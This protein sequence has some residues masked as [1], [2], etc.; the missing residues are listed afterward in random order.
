M[1]ECFGG[2]VG[3]SGYTCFLLFS[4]ANGFS[5]CPAT[6]G[7]SKPLRVALKMC[8]P[9][10]GQDWPSSWGTPPPRWSQGWGR[11][12][13]RLRSLWLALR[14]HCPTLRTQ[15]LRPRQTVHRL[16]LLAQS[17]GRKESYKP[18]CSVL[19]GA[20]ALD[21]NQGRH[22]VRVCLLLNLPR[23][24]SRVINQAAEPS[25][26]K[27]GIYY[28]LWGIPFSRFQTFWLLEERHPS[29]QEGPSLQ[30]VAGCSRD[31][32]CSPIAIPRVLWIPP[33]S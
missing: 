10:G 1:G 6:A 31:F 22:P 9:I 7:S 5:C 26:R 4:R 19:R 17:S 2:Q 28:G 24:F 8:Q 13:W 29:C 25:L 27:H 18:L 23:V 3:V 12:R 14:A 15:K 20:E 21:L 30:H 11:S 33:H 16:L 32:P